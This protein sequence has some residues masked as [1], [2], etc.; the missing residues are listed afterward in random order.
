MFNFSIFMKIYYYAVVL[1]ILGLISCQ[2]EILETEELLLEEE[3]NLYFLYNS[4]SCSYTIN[5]VLYS[6]NRRIT[7]GSSFSQ[8]NPDPLTG[9]GYEDSIY[10]ASGLRLADYNITA[11][12]VFYGEGEMTLYIGQKFSKKELNFDSKNIFVSTGNIDRNIL[13]T[14]GEYPFAIDFHRFN[15]RNGVSISVSARGESGRK[16]TYRTYIYTPLN[17]ETS[18]PMDAHNE[19]YFEI[20]KIHNFSNGWKVIEAVFYATVFES[21]TYAPWS[22]T[23][24]KAFKLEKGYVR[25]R[26]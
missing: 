10:F 16:E 15:T 26:L 25:F 20:T 22:P 19:S 2:G 7:E 21:S 6:C 9:I 18:I 12:N 3:E 17:L 5:N 23:Y 8:V 4:D 11:D 24:E 14:E 13:F 1:V